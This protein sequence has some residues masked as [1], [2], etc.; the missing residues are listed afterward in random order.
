LRSL[1]RL[2]QLRCM[3]RRLRRRNLRRL[4]NYPSQE[5]HQL[6]SSQM[7]PSLNLKCPLLHHPRERK[8]NLLLLLLR[9][10]V[11]R[12]SLCLLLLRRRGRRRR[13]RERK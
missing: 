1:L 7:E 12:L 11:K 4:L 2:N 13:R 8:I 5:K 6:H 9:L 10:R 3:N